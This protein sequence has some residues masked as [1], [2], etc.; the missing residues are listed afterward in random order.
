MY[1]NICFL[2][3]SSIKFE[4]GLYDSNEKMLSVT[5]AGLLL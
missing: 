5:G 3:P 1:K 4:K 2:L